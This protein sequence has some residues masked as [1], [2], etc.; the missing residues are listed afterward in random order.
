MKPFFGSLHIL[1]SYW[2]Q[3]RSNQ[4]ARNLSSMGLAQLTVR[5]S[6]L[7]ATVFLS[8][9][10][11]PNDYG[12]AAIVL[13]VYEF[14]ALFTRN[15]ISAKVVRASEAEVQIVAMTAWRMTWIICGA[16]VVLQSLLAYP[17]AIFYNDQ[18][19]FAPIVAIAM[20]YLI[21][22]M[23]NIQA[24]FQQREGK[25]GRIAFAAATQVVV[26]NF[27]TAIFA[28]L[29]LG[30]WAIILPK[31][32]VA[33]IW[34]IA[35]RLGHPWRPKK[36]DGVNRFEGWREI[37]R[38]SRNVLGSELLS[39]IQGNVDN[40][41]VGFFLGMHALGMYYFAF[42]AGLGLTLGLITAA[43]VAVYPYLC[44]VRLD[45][46][47][48]AERF[49]KTRRKIC[50]G[51]V[52]L[53]LTQSALAPLYVPIIFGSKWIEAVPILCLICL[54]AL[55]RPFASHCSQ[56][57]KAVGKPEIELR[58]QLLN[59]VALIV[60]LIIGSQISILAVA[61]AVFIVQSIVLGLFAYL[62]PKKILHEHQPCLPIHHKDSLAQA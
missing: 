37:T 59:T 19:L 41:F 54:S 36:L 26:D 23:S 34:G 31:I 40:L 5:I 25:L 6:R 45:P 58:W 44:E 12:T 60:A 43:G 21:T 56:L 18:R 48:L 11:L 3:F 27:L 50:F 9:L 16:L 33:P 17:I 2:R 4:F 14:I 20:V 49:Y 29:G 15:G 7:L 62:V 1:D 42:N 28:I 32:L 10:L 8:R 22:P 57:L 55:A 53:I 47:R 13:T 35:V 51:I 38:F 46:E 30:L 39:T 24:A 61:F 52:V